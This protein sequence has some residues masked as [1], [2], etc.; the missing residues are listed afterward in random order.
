[1]AYRIKKTGL[2]KAHGTEAGIK[3]PGLGCSKSSAYMLWLFSLGFCGTPNS[4]NSSVSDSFP[5]V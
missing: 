2:V 1:M 5:Y 3:E 4:G